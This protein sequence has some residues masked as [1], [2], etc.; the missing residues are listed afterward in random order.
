MRFYKKDV[1]GMKIRKFK[2]DINCDS[3][4]RNVMPY[5]NSLRSVVWWQ[6]DKTANEKILT[7]EGTFQD[8]EIEQIAKDA[9]FQAME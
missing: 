5:L 6:V 2:A 3:C 8:Q 9:G 7:D 4:V 1:D